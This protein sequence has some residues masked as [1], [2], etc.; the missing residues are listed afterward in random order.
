M[1]KTIDEV[2]E[3]LEDLVANNYQQ[4]N[5]RNMLR[6]VPGVHEIDVITNIFPKQQLSQVV[7]SNNLT[8]N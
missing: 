4:P 6:K 8:T 5:E 3:L 7:T 1:K 2:Y